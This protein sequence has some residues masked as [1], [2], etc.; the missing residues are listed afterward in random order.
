MVHE[1]VNIHIGQAG[2]G[3]GTSIWDVLVTESGLDEHGNINLE[4]AKKG[5]GLQLNSLF[6]E[7]YH[8]GYSPRACFVDTEPT[9]IDEMFQ[10]GG[11]KHL[12]VN[13]YAIVGNDDASNCYARGKFHSGKLIHDQVMTTIR[14]LLENCDSPNAICSY[15]SLC[16]GTGSGYTSKLIAAV[17]DKLEKITFH[18]HSLIPSHSLTAHVVEP[19]NAVLALAETLKMMDVHFIYDNESCYKLYETAHKLQRIET[20][21]HHINH[22]VGQ[23]LSGMTCC[24]RWSTQMDC[25]LDQFQTNLVPFPNINLISPSFVPINYN[26]SKSNMSIYGITAESFLNNH[27]MCPLDPTEGDYI[28]CCTIYRGLNCD[29]K[30]VYDAVESVRSS[31]KIPFVKWIPTGFKIGICDSQIYHPN[32]QMESYKIPEASLL[33]FTNHT[34]MFDVCNDTVDKYNALLDKRG[35]VF[36]YIGEGMEEGEFVDA[37]ETLVEHHK[38]MKVT[39]SAV[40]GNDDDDADADADDDGDN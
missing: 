40:D 15:N 18:A 2:I 34:G 36:W 6:S 21:Y 19:Y 39:C 27:E 35:Y 30:D 3:M 28:A 25:D 23:V 4:S 26:H 38:L 33:K 31:F 37:A 10:T 16:G 5:M 22:L 17:G 14:R 11:Y 7:K 24:Q 1:I 29:V 13:E 20:T 12:F 9:V 32:K 8:G